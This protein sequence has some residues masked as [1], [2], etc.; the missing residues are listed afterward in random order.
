MNKIRKIL[1]IK[2]A[3]KKVLWFLASIFVIFFILFIVLK[4][5][6]SIN[7]IQTHLFSANELY[8]KLDKKLTLKA[9]KIH[10]FESKD[11][12]AEFDLTQLMQVAQKLKYLY[13]FFQ[14]IDIAEL[15]SGDHHVTLSFKDGEFAASHDFFSIRLSIQK[16]GHTINARV[17]ELMLTGSDANVSVDL[18]IDTQKNQYSF[19]GTLESERTYFDFIFGFNPKQALFR[20]DNITIKDIKYIFDYFKQVGINLGVNVATWV[21]EK[22]AAK[23]YHFDYVQGRINLGKKMQITELL[24]T[25]FADGLIVK[26]DESI[27]DISIPHVDINLSKEKLDFSFNKALFN[28]KDLSESEIFIYDIAY[29]EKTGISV[30]IKSKE[31]TLDEKLQDLLRY[32]GIKIPLTQLSGKMSSDFVIKI[33]FSN[34][35]N[36]FYKG[37]FEVKEAGF[38]KANLLVHKGKVTL[39]DQKVF[40]DAFKVSNA[41]LSSDL[42]A[43]IDILAKTG[44]F[45]T[46]ITKLHFDGLLE[47]QD[48]FARLHLSYKDDIIV[49]IKEWGLNMNF[50]EGLKLQSSKLIDF[51]PYSPILQNFKVED[52][53][54]FTLDTKDFEGFNV[55]LDNVHFENDLFKSNMQAYNNDDFFIEKKG[56]IIKIRTKSDLISA[57]IHENTINANVKNLYYRF[58]DSAQMNQSQDYNIELYASNFGL[59]LEDFEKTLHFDHLNLN[60]YGG[61]ITARADKNNA[62]F[63]LRKNDKELMLKANGI[64]DVFL[65]TFFRKNMVENGKFGFIIQ[66]DNEKSFEGKIVFYNTYFKDLKAHNQLISFI[67]TIPSLALFKNPTFNE[68]GLKVK[69]G[70]ILF[71]RVNDDIGINALTFNGDSVNV[72]GMGDIDLKRKTVDM[73]L[74]LRTLKS[75]SELI[76]KVPI[77][78]Q[79]ILGKDRV[80]STQLVVDGTIDNPQFHSQIIKETLKLPF[81]I[82]KNIIELP[83]TLAQ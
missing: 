65:N 43:T 23:Y 40:L 46:N 30:G 60:A 71:T 33:P 51:K 61:M 72:L 48:E 10:I 3:K 32:Y 7:S 11:E 58:K 79:I 1:T 76:S 37:E 26:I 27:E 83:A 45:D 57:N 39:K 50:T 66:G 6:F 5:G 44:L 28:G 73:E 54:N 19:A 82:L 64:N 21:S 56:S 34:P 78:N 69:K 53:D 22:A 62:V 42:N 31:L 38:D 77:I 16:T 47:M 18:S 9:K 20:F 17:K 35:A 15:E 12:N 25:G 80:I 29:P 59:L 2:N 8:I 24:G 55:R 41:F 52:V 49:N 4:I 74:E 70:V 75:A 81:N 13:F 68:K 63:E 67:D 14:E 36:N